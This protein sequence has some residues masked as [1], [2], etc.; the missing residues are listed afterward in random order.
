MKESSAM[1]HRLALPLPSFAPGSM[2]RRGSAWL[3]LV[4]LA[5]AA[6]ATAPASGGDGKPAAGSASLDG[7]LALIGAAR[8]EVDAQCRT[9]AI[10]HKACGGPEAYLAWSVS[11]TDAAALNRAAAAYA[12]SRR[13]AQ[14]A[15]GRM[16]NCQFV[17]DPGASCAAV[18]GQPGAAKRCQL[19]SAPG[20]AD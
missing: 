9:L 19:G 11:D 18:K 3:L 8:C 13:T 6:P 4:A 5:A 14:Q 7:I 16:S 10:G 1:T 20:R 17:T 12:E 2:R 15:S